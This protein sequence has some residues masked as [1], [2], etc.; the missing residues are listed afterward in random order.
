MGC[1]SFLMFPL[2]LAGTAASAAGILLVVSGFKIRHAG[3][4]ALGGALGGAGMLLGYFWWLG[5]ATAVAGGV[6]FMKYRALPRP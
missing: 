2:K 5:L 1:G 3:F 6:G 4:C